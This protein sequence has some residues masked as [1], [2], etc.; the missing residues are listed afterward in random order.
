MSL[1]TFIIGLVSSFG[2]AWLG[3]VVIPFFKMRNLEPLVHAE[4]TE[5][6]GEVY[7]P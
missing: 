1:R 2:I 4:G 6:A 3:M 7:F 5:Q